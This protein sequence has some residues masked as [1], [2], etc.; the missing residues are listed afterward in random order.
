MA[1]PGRIWSCVL[2]GLALTALSACGGNP[3]GPS[4]GGPTPTPP[5]TPPPPVVVIQQQGFALQVEFLGR[6]PFT[7]TRAGAL[8]AIADWTFATNDVDVAIT[9]GDCSFDQFEAAQCEILAM[10]IS[11]TT[12]PERAN[13]QSAAV[14]TYTLFVANFGPTAESISYQVVL[15]PSATGSGSF[16]AAG[17]AANGSPF[18]FKARPRGRTELR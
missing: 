10:T 6:R 4:G 11:T 12:K 5:P 13:V 9:R 18:P 1:L 3:A 7:T 2:T 14:G 17:S 15:T 8:E 16:E